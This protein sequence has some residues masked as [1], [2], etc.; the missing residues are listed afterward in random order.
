M[1]T[2]RELSHGGSTILQAERLRLILA[3]NSDPFPVSPHSKRNVPQEESNH[4]RIALPIAAALVLLIVL[5]VE[6]QAPLGG[7]FAGSARQTPINQS[8]IQG[9]IVFLDTG[10]SVHGLVVSGK[11]TG[12]DPTQTYFS[13]LY[14]TSSLP[15]GPNACVPDPKA[16]PI[17]DAQ[18]FTNFWS[19]APDGTGTL[20]RQKTGAA[21]VAL[22]DVATVS[23]RKVTPGMNPPF[24]EI[25]QAC[26][27][28]NVNP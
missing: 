11:A 12:L 16:P 17:T 15:G 26:G 5:A 24:I 7:Q 9:E 10:S 14:N 23:I 20:F 6:A 19:V 8:G 13:L 18:M 27:R 1:P 2:T 4:E 22:S 25:L 3:S 21:Y 28:I